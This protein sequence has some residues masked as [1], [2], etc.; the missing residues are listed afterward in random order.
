LVWMWLNLPASCVFW[1]T[2]DNFCMFSLAAWRLQLPMANRN[3]AS[4]LCAQLKMPH[5]W[6]D[7]IYGMGL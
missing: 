6:R 4:S 5:Y 3:R 1:R 2:S 7:I